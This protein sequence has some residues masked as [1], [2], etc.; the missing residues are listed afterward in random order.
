LDTALEIVEG[1]ERAD[2]DFRRHEFLIIR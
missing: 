2:S 1:V